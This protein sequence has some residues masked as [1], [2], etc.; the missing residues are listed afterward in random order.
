MAEKKEV[1]AA[2]LTTY[3]MLQN[4]DLKSAEGEIPPVF[5]ELRRL[6]VKIVSK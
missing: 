2:T 5:P 4:F 6:P 1:C 3:S